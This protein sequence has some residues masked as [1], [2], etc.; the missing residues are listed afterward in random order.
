MKRSLCAAFSLSLAL[1]SSIAYAG[2]PAPLPPGKPSGVKQA[3]VDRQTVFVIGGG[4]FSVT[5]FALLI[6]AT[7]HGSSSPLSIG[8]SSN[9]LSAGSTSTTTTTT[10]SSAITTTTR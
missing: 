10:T 5:G 8:G 1:V 2:D 7:Q 3:Q 6:A 4:L 9:Q